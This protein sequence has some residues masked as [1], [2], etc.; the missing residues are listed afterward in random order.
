VV[1]DVRLDDWA[2]SDGQLPTVEFRESGWLLVQAIT[3]N[4]RTFR[5]ASTGPVYV[6]NWRPNGESARQRRSSS[7]IGCTNGPGRSSCRTR[8]NVTP[9]SDTIAPPA[10]TG[11]SW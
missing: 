3:S 11:S 8:R 9:C 7:W 1:H 4:P 6:E 2:K 10:T 5:F